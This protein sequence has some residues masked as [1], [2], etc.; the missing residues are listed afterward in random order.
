MIALLKSGRRDSNSRPPAP[1][2]GA[3]T[4][5][6]Y[7]P[8]IFCESCR[9]SSDCVL[10]SFK[11]PIGLEDLFIKLSK[12]GIIHSSGEGGIRTLGTLFKVRR[13]SKP[14]V[15]ATHPP[16]R[17]CWSAISHTDLK[18]SPLRYSSDIQDFRAL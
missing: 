2:A 14:S 6:R 8:N 18:R 5:L 7:A 10:T 11:H 17:V 3:L 16:H 1:K 12:T 15:S 13:F 4:G 9:Q